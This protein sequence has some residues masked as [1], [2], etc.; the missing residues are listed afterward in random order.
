MSANTW[1][2][3]V[4]NWQIELGKTLSNDCV[5]HLSDQIKNPPPSW[6]GN[7]TPLKKQKKNHHQEQITVNSDFIILYILVFK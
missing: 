7:I 5:T 1:T 2:Y 3:T 4:I 6:C